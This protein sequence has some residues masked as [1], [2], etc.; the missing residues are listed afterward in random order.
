VL[1][2]RAGFFPTQ[3][4]DEMMLADWNKVIGMNLTGVFLMVKAVLPLMKGRGSGRIVNIRFDKAKANAVLASGN[5]D[6]VA[7]GVP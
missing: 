3:S 1:I 7:F 4:F 2:N 6:L 5:A